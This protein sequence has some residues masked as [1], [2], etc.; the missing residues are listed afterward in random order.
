MNAQT[1]TLTGQREFPAR[2]RQQDKHSTAE[3]WSNLNKKRDRSVSAH[4]ADGTSFRQAQSLQGANSIVLYIA[5]GG[6]LMAWAECRDGGVVNSVARLGGNLRLLGLAEA[7]HGNHVAAE[8][9]HGIDQ[10]SCVKSEWSSA[11]L[12]LWGRGAASRRRRPI[13][14]M[15]IPKDG[16]RGLVASDPVSSGIAQG[17]GRS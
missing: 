1:K 4:H 16:T 10:R 17:Q 9:S 11:G 13:K 5:M 7:V 2:S 15:D 3:L 14:M 12:N 8:M 6:R